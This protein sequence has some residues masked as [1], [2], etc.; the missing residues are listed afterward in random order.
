M[1]ETVQ[2]RAEDRVEVIHRAQMRVERDT[3]SYPVTVRNLSTQGMMGEGHVPL[4][5]GTRL[6]VSLPD[7]GEVAGTVV[8]VQKPRFGVAF[9]RSVDPSFA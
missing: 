8:W 5:S 2:R 7:Q 6:T 9:D 3:L 4:S 1:A